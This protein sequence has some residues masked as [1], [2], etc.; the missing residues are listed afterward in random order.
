MNTDMITV[1]VN[2]LPT[3]VA[4]S[5]SS[6]VCM[7]SSVTLSGS[8]ATS[9]SWSGGVTDNVPFTP[10]ST[11]TYTVTGTDANGCMNTDVAT[12]TVN[13]LPIVD[14]ND[15]TQCG[16][17]VTLD[18]Q[19][20]GSTYLW[21]TTAT[22]QAITTSTSGTFYVDVM[23]ANGCVGSDTAV[24]VINTPP[25]VNGTAAF[26]TV[27]LSDAPDALTGT[28][29]GGTWSGP[30]VSGSSLN[31]A[32][33]GVGTH[34]ATYSFTDANGCSGTSSVAITV[35]ACVGVVEQTLENGISI[36]PNPSNGTFTLAVDANVGDLVIVITDMQGRVVYS[37]N[38]SN[39]QAGFVKQINLENAAAGMYLM[40]IS[41]NGQTRT[42][43]I[44]VQK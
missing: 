12:V 22:T 3:V 29:A 31:P 20:Q 23:D 16:G 41:A 17:T 11:N 44:S 27:C 39:V 5:T 4:N 34:S 42:D 26:T 36:Y 19:N 33:A 37:S 2:A 14:L 35:N 43:K 30:G 24:I 13:P 21:N 18:A 25:T 8:G 38:E 7:G 9:Y 32:T 40:H 1:T 10:T 28:P 15:I 6:S